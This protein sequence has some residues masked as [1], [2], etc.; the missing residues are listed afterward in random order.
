M[1]NYTN[2]DEYAYSD[3]GTQQTTTPSSK[4]KNKVPGIILMVLGVIFLIGGIITVLLQ[5][6]LA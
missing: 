3:A 4:K 5:K 1:D 2:F 6:I